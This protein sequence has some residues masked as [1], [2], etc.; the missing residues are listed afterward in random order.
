M[1]RINFLKNIVAYKYNKVKSYSDE[2]LLDLKSNHR[3][4]CIQWAFKNYLYYFIIKLKT[5]NQYNFFSSLNYL[6][7]YKLQFYVSFF[8]F[9]LKNTKTQKKEILEA[10]ISIHLSNNLINWKSWLKDKNKLLT[11]VIKLKR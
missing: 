1:K 10:L 7:S 4:L 11:T 6:I 8:V 5:N 3:K 2:I 9:Y